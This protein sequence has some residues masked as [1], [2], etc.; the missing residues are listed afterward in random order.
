MRYGRGSL[1]DA[2]DGPA[3]SLLRAAFPLEAMLLWE[4]S[5]LTLDHI[6]RRIGF[7]PFDLDWPSCGAMRR[8]YAG[9]NAVGL[10]DVY[11]PISRAEALGFSALFPRSSRAYPLD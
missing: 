1:A 4:A 9:A 6:A 11:P 2:G 7:E 5:A 3:S 8:L 10:A